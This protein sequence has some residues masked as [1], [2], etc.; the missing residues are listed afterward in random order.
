MPKQS[1]P[2]CGTPAGYEPDD[3]GRNKKFDCPK[4]KYFFISPDTEQKV[5]TLPEKEKIK[6]SEESAQ[7]RANEVLLIRTDDNGVIQRNCIQ[8]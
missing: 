7:C 5:N 8:A 2:L 4:C 6:L 3:Y 1:C